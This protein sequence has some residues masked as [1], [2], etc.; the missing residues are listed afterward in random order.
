[1]VKIILKFGEMIHFYDVQ[2]FVLTLVVFPQVHV[3]LLVENICYYG[4]ELRTQPVHSWQPA[5]LLDA[6]PHQACCP[7]PGIMMLSLYKKFGMG[8]LLLS[9]LFVIIYQSIS[10]FTATCALILCVELNNLVENFPGGS[11]SPLLLFSADFRHYQLQI[12]NKGGLSFEIQEK[13]YF[14]QFFFQFSISI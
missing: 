6:C 5:R 13:N 4:E 11:S 7:S 3:E 12:S 9:I 1:M 14:P 10:W 8:G 2:W